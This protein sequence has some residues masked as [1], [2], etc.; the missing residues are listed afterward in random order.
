MTELE[1]LQFINDAKDEQGNNIFNASQDV[2][3]VQAGNGTTTNF[4]RS[5]YRWVNRDG[6][7]DIQTIKIR[8]ANHRVV[9]RD[10]ENNGNTPWENKYNID[11][12]FDNNVQEDADKRCHRFFVIEE[13]IYRISEMTPKKLQKIINAVLKVGDNG[14]KDPVKLAH[15][16]VLQPRYMYEPEKKILPPTDG[17]VH[18]HQVEVW[19]AYEKKQKG[20]KTNESLSDRRRILPF[21]AFCI[22]S[23]RNINKVYN[24]TETNMVHIKKLNE[25]IGDKYYLYKGYHEAYISDR[26]V[27]GTTNNR[28]SEYRTFNDAY[29]AAEKL[30]VDILYSDGLRDEVCDFFGDRNYCDEN[31]ELFF[32]PDE[33]IR[34]SRRASA[35]GRAI[36]EWGSFGDDN[37]VD[38]WGEISGLSELYKFDKLCPDAELTDDDVKDSLQIFGIDTPLTNIGK[39]YYDAIFKAF[40]REMQ[41]EYGLS[42][43]EV[44]KIEM[45]FNPVEFRFGNDY[46]TTKDEFEKILDKRRFRK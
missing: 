42:D 45:S 6:G 15:N 18:E 16:Y 17:S 12:V 35:R 27:A 39:A 9:M 24:I 4:F 29:E 7:N 20:D 46:F 36:N 11:I 25:M 10:W 37:W 31:P 30:G 40:V 33:P 21:D 23:S 22:N 28:P 2:G 41:E 19:Q 32:N 43:D 44:E 26:P 8:A 1:I 5:F 3:P 38:F 13:Y 34:E 14:F